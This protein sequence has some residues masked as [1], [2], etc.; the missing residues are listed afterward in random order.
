MVKYLTNGQVCD[1]S[2]LDTDKERIFQVAASEGH[3]QVVQVFVLEQKFLPNM[4]GRHLGGGGR[5]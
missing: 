5:C 4:S 3:L 1:P 2:L